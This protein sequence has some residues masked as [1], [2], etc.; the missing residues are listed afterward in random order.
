MVIIV[1]QLTAVNNVRMD[2]T[3]L[4]VSHIQRQPRAK[5]VKSFGL[6]DDDSL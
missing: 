2:D 3:S 1:W 6:I 5:P 4:G